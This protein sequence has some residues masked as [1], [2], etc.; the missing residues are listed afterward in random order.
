MALI[1]APLELG[2]I[3]DKTVK[4]IGK[5]AKRN[6]A[7]A[8]II[9]LPLTVVMTL[10]MSSI[11]Q[12][13]S[14]II[15][16][17]VEAKEAGNTLSETDIRDI[18]MPFLKILPLA[19]GAGLLY[20]IGMAAAE[21]A[22]IRI[23]CYQVDEKNITW[24][25]ALNSAFGGT[26]WRLI[27]QRLL[28][29]IALVGISFVAMIPVAL[30]P[31][32]LILTFP[33]LFIAWAWIWTRWFLAPQV[34]V[35]EES[36]VFNSFSR[37]SD[38]VHGQFWRI[39][40]IGLLLTII[41]SIAISIISTPIQMIAMSG[42]WSGYMDM[43]THAGDQTNPAEQLRT[44]ATMFSGMGIGYGIAIGV[45]TILMLMVQPSYQVVM[46]YDACARHGELE[47]EDGV[48]NDDDF[49]LS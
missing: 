44:M 22:I 5:T 34:I 8:A 7:V 10:I 16:A 9:I 33:A 15:L 27:G 30:S 19:F 28:F 18:I 11:M 48:N 46:Y 14:A 47:L 17:F 20:L 32:F 12:D 25:D 40:G 21:S 37:S 6:V 31:L 35:N 2:D 3:F 42:F 4:L 43:I 45:Q 1:T 36:G 23:N 39:L 26:M 13:Y 49:L 24:R 38:L 41:S 29:V